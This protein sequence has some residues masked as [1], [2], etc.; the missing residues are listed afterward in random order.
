MEKKSFSLISP[1]Y[2][3]R[4]KQ[5][6]AFSAEKVL[7]NRV[8]L[9]ILQGGRASDLQKVVARRAICGTLFGLLGNWGLMNQIKHIV[10]IQ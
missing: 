4:T 5:Q 7:Q 10:Y 1:F 9:S 6:N 3:P 8:N 2:F